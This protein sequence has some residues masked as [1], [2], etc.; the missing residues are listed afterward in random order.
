MEILES[1]I[2]SANSVGH[3]TY[4]YTNNGYD[5]SA[6][7]YLIDHVGREICNWNPLFDGAQAMLLLKAHQF[8]VSPEMSRGGWSIG[9]VVDENEGFEWLSFDEDLNKAIVIA[10]AKIQKVKNK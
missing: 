8:T 10:A 5:G 3:K 7:I 9:A 1:L 4:D 6:G 2:L